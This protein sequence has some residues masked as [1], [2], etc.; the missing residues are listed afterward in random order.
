MF[1]TTLRSTLRTATARRVG[2]PRPLGAVAMMRRSGQHAPIHSTAA[3]W[4][5]T[6]DHMAAIGIELPPYQDAVWSYVKAQRDGDKFYIGDHVGQD[7]NAVTVRGKVGEKGTEGAEVTPEEAELLARNGEFWLPN[8]DDG[9]VHDRQ[10]RP[11][12]T[13]PLS[14][15]PCAS[16]RASS[17][18]G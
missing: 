10:S 8:A 12:R 7:E 5:A 18:N 3:R 13:P 4:G 6:E 14:S 11:T 17:A 9:H 16:E 15:T 2:A 1:A